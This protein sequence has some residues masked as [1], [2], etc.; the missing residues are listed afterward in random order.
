MPNIVKTYYPCPW[1]LT[2]D[3]NSFKDFE[4]GIKEVEKET[5]EWISDYDKTNEAP[6]WLEAVA[7]LISPV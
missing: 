4:D 1:E 6:L 7:T 5:R 2:L 3:Y